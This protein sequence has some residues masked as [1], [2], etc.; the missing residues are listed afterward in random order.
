MFFLGL[1]TF[2]LASVL[3]L[4][5]L[6]LVAWQLV[7]KQTEISALVRILTNLGFGLHTLS[8]IALLIMQV[9]QD[10]SNSYVVGVI[11]PA[12]PTYLKLT[13]LWGGQAGSLFF[14][15]WIINLCLVI[16]LNRRHILR[17][18]WGYLFALIN[19]I[20]FSGISLFLENPFS[21]VWQLTNG[22]LIDSLFS[23][24]EGAQVYSGLIGTG[25]NPLLRHWGMIIH[26]P[27][28][29]IGFGAFLLPF[30]ETLSHLILK[31]D[32]E[33][34][35][36]RLRPW[37]LI[38][39]IFL[40]AGIVLG[41]WWSYDVL[42][43][44]GYWA[45]DPVETASLIPWLISTGL[46]HSMFLQQKKN[47]FRRI[48][49]ILILGSYL[50]IL[51]SILITRAGLI[52]SVHAF[53]ESSISIPLT[54][55]LLAS[56]VLSVGLLIWRWKKMDSGWEFESWYGRDSL[57]LYTL[58]LLAAIALVCMWGL[59]YPL[60]T[61]AFTGNEIILDRGFYDRAVTPLL[62][63]LVLLMAVCPLVGWSVAS[64]KK[65]GNRAL[66][67]LIAAVL[68]T[69][70]AFVWLSKSWVALL[71]IFIVALGLMVL[72]LTTIRDLRTAEKPLGTFW[73][74][75][76]RYGAFLVHSGILLI[77]LGIVGV[78]GLSQSIVGTLIPGDKMPLGDYGVE[79]RELT[80]SFDSP[81]YLSVRAQIDLWQ[82]DKVVARLTP[83]QDVYASRSQYV[84][85]PGKHSTL[86]GDFYTIMLDYDSMMGYISLQAT[87]NP[88]VNFM[89]IGSL[90]LCLGAAFSLSSPM[91]LEQANWDRKESE[92][93]EETDAD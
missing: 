55:F 6:V 14:W 13:A 58:V 59:L 69:V 26:P 11:N 40:T 54:L 85:I 12:L 52:S 31:G 90:F 15:S 2:I 63:L 28:L 83:G 70:A 73:K 5:C 76:S 1:G 16:A 4:V 17:D 36:A 27:V 10:Y 71:S 89:W 60:A 68:A 30:S 84:S 41:S 18:N 56:L 77:M 23:P 62:V 53:G 80:E 50:L 82:G 9:S 35:V 19:L 38:A 7:H 67:P 51:F 86:A 29:Y 33:D 88:L 74:M 49:V 92:E 43:W 72:V 32:G 78:E 75:R 24:A 48:N 20:F 45:W 22:N 46:L 66:I 64:L 44:G 57:F 8:I 61:G 87:I 21:R 47:I 42:G 37:L 65:L 93:D 39:W 79:Y 34:L 91:V 25:L 3:M 81:E